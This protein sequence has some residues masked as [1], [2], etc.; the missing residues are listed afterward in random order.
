MDLNRRFGFVSFDL[1]GVAVMPDRNLEGS[2]G[3]DS[4]SS[5]GILSLLPFTAVVVLLICCVFRCIARCRW[6]GESCVPGTSCA[7]ARVNAS[8]LTF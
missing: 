6:P 3:Y 2:R 7:C 1:I 4:L 5:P 8:L